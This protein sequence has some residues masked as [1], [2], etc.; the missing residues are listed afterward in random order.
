M[1]A[2]ARV[3]RAVD[4]REALVRATINVKVVR[5]ANLLQVQ[6]DTA[7][8]AVVKAV[9]KG[10]VKAARKGAR[11]VMVKTV[12]AA[13]KAMIKGVVKG[14]IRIVIKT[15]IRT[16]EAMVKIIQKKNN[17]TQ[18]TIKVVVI[19]I[20][21]I[22]TIPLIP[23]KVEIQTIPMMEEIQTIPMKVMDLIPL[24]FKTQTIHLHPHLQTKTL[25][26]VIHPLPQKFPPTIHNKAPYS[27]YKR[28]YGF[29]STLQY[30]LM[31]R[32]SDSCQNFNCYFRC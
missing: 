32:S 9:V 1:K 13:R 29:V 23:M 30:E 2:I 4:V 10:V 27:E 12:E 20:K 5:G 16:V 3:N 21:I 8:K 19:L 31:L 7:R 14:V 18:M 26:T 22:P 17:R 24:R 15:V 6:V 25:T 28:K 11:K